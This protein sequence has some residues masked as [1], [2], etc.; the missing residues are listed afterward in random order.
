MY[1]DA[2]LLRPVCF[3]HFAGRPFVMAACLKN[4]DILLL[5][6]YDDVIPQVSFFYYVLDSTTNTR[7]I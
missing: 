7:N 4:G 3:Y 1:P 6:S 2:F 5:R